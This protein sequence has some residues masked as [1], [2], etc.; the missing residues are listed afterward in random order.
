MIKRRLRL[1]IVDDEKD[2]CK[3]VRSIF[4]KKGFIT[5]GAFSGRQALKVAKR[6]K[7]DIAL[8]DLYLLRG[9]NGL[10][11]VKA[12]KTIAPECL[13]AMITWDTSREKVK[14]AKKY[15]AVSYIAKPLTVKRLQKSVG[16]LVRK[17]SKGGKGNG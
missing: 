1:M 17:V 7:P 5:Y 15:G 14:Q 11:T 12:L 8:V 6:V 4:K 3:F 13:S 10:K 16:R 9:I 2:V